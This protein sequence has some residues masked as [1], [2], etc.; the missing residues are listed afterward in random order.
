MSD[1]E[2]EGVRRIVY[3]EG[4]TFIPVCVK[5]GRFV[6]PDEIVFTSEG[7][8]LKKQPNATCKKCGRTE[9]LFE[10]FI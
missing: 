9:M 3:G 1:Y 4:A 2:Y 10:G 7:A 8:G 5:C 6:K